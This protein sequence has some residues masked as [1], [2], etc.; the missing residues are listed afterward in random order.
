[1]TDLE[2]TEEGQDPAH[3][4][5]LRKYKKKLAAEVENICNDLIGL[6]DTYLLPNAKDNAALVFYLKMKGDYYR[7]WAE[8]LTGDRNKTI[9]NRANESYRKAAERAE[10]LGPANP[11]KL[12]LALNYSVFQYEIMNSPETACKVAKAGFQAAESELGKLDEEKYKEASTIMGLLKDNLKLWEADV[13][14]G[15]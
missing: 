3:V 1:M 11:I 8:F 6:L 12:G 4:E 14:G 7:Y 15:E 10:V 2:Q 5:L 13:T 9:A